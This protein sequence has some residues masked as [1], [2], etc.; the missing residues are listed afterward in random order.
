MSVLPLQWTL[1]RPVLFCAVL[2]ERERE[3]ERDGCNFEEAVTVTSFEG[4]RDGQSVRGR[5]TANNVRN[6]V[7]DMLELFPGKCQKY[8][9]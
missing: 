6:T 2:L 7:A 4:V 3:R 9:Q 5:L 1:L 8:E